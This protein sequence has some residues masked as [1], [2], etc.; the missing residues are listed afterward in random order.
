MG[1][2]DKL[3][4]AVNAVTGGAA[5]V[6]VEVLQPSA[7]AGE[8]TKVRVTT[9]S[10]G[11]EVKSQGIFVDV[12][13]EEQVNIVDPSTK[14]K[15]SQSKAT[16]E[17]T[18]QIA[19]ALVLA[20]NESKSFEGTIQLPASALPSFEGALAKHVY[21]IRGRMEAFGNDPDSG[22]QPLKVTAKG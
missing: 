12:K 10:T 13:G 22:F 6:T 20:A 18:F 21:W 9:T 19:P 2:F 4:S 16:I 14:Q 3:K 15:V 11:A 8:P 17:Q 7:V 5:K 1:F